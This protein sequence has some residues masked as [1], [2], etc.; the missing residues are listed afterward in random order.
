MIKTINKAL[1][2]FKNM[3]FQ[4]LL[5]NG[6]MALFGMITLSI[7]YRSLTVTDI[8]I[9]IFFL[10][11][12]GLMDNL[13]AGFLTITIVKFFSGTS[14]ERGL[15]VAGSAWLLALVVSAT[16]III[17][18]PTY[19]IANYVSDKGLV[20]FLKYFSIISL[21]TLPC[22]MTDCIVQASKRFDRLLWLRV[23]NQGAYTVSIFAFAFLGKLNLT[24]VMYTFIGSNLFAG[25]IVLAL[26]WTMISSVFKAKSNTAWE[27]FHFGK[28]SMGTNISSNLFGVTNT[29]II[30]F[31]IGPAA[32]AMYNLGGKL[33][34]IVEIPLLSFVTSGMPLLS[35]NYNNGEKAR[36]VYT[37]KKLVG[38]LTIVL[39]PVV[40]L[41][42]IFAEPI[43][44]L[45]GGKGYVANEAPNL[46]RIFMIIA[47][48]YPADRFFAI[49]VDII[50]QPK[51]NF[52][53]I[54]VMSLVNIAAVFAFV[55]IYHSV[56]SVAIASVT[57]ILVA[58]YMTYK[59][60][61][62]YFK[63]NFFDIYRVG[64]KEVKNS[65][66]VLLNNFR[67]H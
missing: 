53:K 67:K 33:L 23:F 41:S 61:N 66:I 45:L 58:I 3:H 10:A 42:V 64:F 36:M 7:L 13:R 43:I 26:R 62:N 40:I 44:N 4:S 2:I 20:L 15:E 49:G 56:Y 8:G 24:T 50:H 14:E 54:I 29:F 32:L 59:P 18:I 51:I 60:L 27:L 48:L 22:F 5:A 37:L 9:Y 19:F 39:I 16:F 65:S 17:N 38:M 34:Q 46:F 57:P 6:M 12:I 31:L 47:L 28:Y 63:F 55:G 11:I 30:N 35:T 25:I 21:I 52:Y 1:T